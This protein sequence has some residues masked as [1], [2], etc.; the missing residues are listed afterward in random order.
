MAD[1][2][3]FTIPEAN[4]QLGADRSV[5]AEVDVTSRLGR[6]A[7]V[8]VEVLPGEGTDPAWFEPPAPR[9]FDLA[10]GATLRTTV[11]IAV[12]DD[13]PPGDHQFALRAYAVGNPAQEFTIGPSLSLTVPSTE[14]RRDVPRWIFVLIALTVVV[15]VALVL[16]LIFGG[17]DEDAGP[18]TTAPVTTITES[19]GDDCLPYDPDDLSIVDEGASG[20]LLTDGRSRML[21]LDA[22]ADAEAALALTRRHDSQCFIGRGNSRTNRSSYIV[23][24]WI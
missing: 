7:D 9:E 22:E 17:D 12:P 11:P 2:F 19:F 5:R 21:V 16:W 24:Y 1:L 23:D 18:A 3:E 4:L 10:D 15:V 14:P 20:W 8:G 13:A 6:R